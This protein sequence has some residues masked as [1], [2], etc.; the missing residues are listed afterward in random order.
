MIRHPQPALIAFAVGLMGLG[1]LALIFGDFALVWQPVP[2]SLPGRT[3]LAYLSGLLMLFGGIGLLLR[4][5]AAWS[6]RILC[7]YL[8]VWMLLKLPALF[9]APGMEAVW[10][11]FGEIAV[12]FC[13]GWTLF[14]TLGETRSGSW[15]AFASGHRGTRLAA[16]LFAVSLIPIG[17]SHIVYTPQT[18]ELI[19]AWLPFRTP[20]ST[21]R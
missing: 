13:G 19:P 21:L 10:L 9:V 7:V 4:P 1:I 17:L 8:F 2:A 5:A 11:G 18:V 12:L 6:A 20:L 3:A 14:A 16:M 15:L